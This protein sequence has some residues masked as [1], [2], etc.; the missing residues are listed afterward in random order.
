MPLFQAFKFDLAGLV[1]ASQPV[2]QNKQAKAG[3]DK[4]TQVQVKNVL[5][6]NSKLEKATCC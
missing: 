5:I 2:I 1:N 6:S 4:F 3:Q